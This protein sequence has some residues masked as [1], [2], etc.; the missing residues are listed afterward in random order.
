LGSVARIGRL[1]ASSGRYRRADPFLTADDHRAIQGEPRSRVAASRPEG[2]SV[3]PIA[4]RVLKQLVGLSRSDATEQLKPRSRFQAFEA[5][6]YRADSLNARNPRAVAKPRSISA[7][8]R[9]CDFAKS[10]FALGPQNL[11]LCARLSMPSGRQLA[12]PG[13]RH[14]GE[15][16]LASLATFWV[17]GRLSTCSTS[18]SGTLCVTS[19]RRS[20]SVRSVNRHPTLTPRFSAKRLEQQQDW[21]I[22]QNMDGVRS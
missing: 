20:C 8:A 18:S 21:R 5:K 17:L 10:R 22:P 6:T 2:A 1:A 9:F 16:P 13:W 19:T 14:V 7:R 11:G 12:T 15:H 4:R 3:E